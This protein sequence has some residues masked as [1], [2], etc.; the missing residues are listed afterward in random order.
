VLG[1]RIIRGGPIVTGPTFEVVGVD[2]GGT[3]D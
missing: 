3:L 2:S 1:C